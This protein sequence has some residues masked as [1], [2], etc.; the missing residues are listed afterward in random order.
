MSA[1]TERE[2]EERGVRES[3]GERR[4][5]GERE[6][7]RKGGLGE[8]QKKKEK[9]IREALRA[10]RLYTQSSIAES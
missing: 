1:D 5:S 3:E 10:F 7:E 2:R 9:K 4:E 6:R 8:R